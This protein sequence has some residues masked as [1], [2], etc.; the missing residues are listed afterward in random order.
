MKES[1]KL[2]S[3]IEAPM[4]LFNKIG[5]TTYHPPV[6]VSVNPKRESLSTDTRIP[7]IP[8]PCG[9]IT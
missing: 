4:I 9:V 2:V 1:L 5:L 8:S 6:R 3:S 7:T